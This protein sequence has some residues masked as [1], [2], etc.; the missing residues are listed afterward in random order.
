MRK[1]TVDQLREYAQRI[2]FH[3]FDPEEFLAHYNSNGWH[4][5]KVKMVSWR[6]TVVTWKKHAARFGR[7]KQQR[8]PLPPIHVRNKIIN[9][10]NR[11]KAEL[12]RQPESAERD[13]KLEQ[14]RIRLC[15][16]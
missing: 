7:R 3:D 1:P 11:R 14:I 15:E 10:L 8:Q 6:H 4:V 12:M 2:G 5:G 16:L 9:D 13:R